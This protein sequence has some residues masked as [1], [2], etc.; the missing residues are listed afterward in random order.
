MGRRGPKPKP[1]HILRLR[2]SWRGKKRN[3]PENIDHK[4]PQRPIWLKNEAKKC[5]D[6]IVPILHAAGLAT[7]LNRETLALLCSAWAD[8]VEADEQLTAALNKDGKRALLIKTANGAIMENPLLYTRKRA[9]DQVFKAA[10]SFGMTPADLGSVRAVN[11]PS[12]DDVKTK[13]FKDGA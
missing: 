6:R 12:K 7:E 3:I 8:Y 1:G 10:S 9:W 11:K 5:W 4:R 13:F 2:G